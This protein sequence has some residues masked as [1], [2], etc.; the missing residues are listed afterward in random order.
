MVHLEHPDGSTVE[1]IPEDVVP[2]VGRMSLGPFSDPGL[3]VIRSD[4]KPVR[5]LVT[6]VNDGERAASLPSA[7]PEAVDDWLEPQDMG[8]TIAEISAGSAEL[9]R[10]LVL[11]ALGML[12][13]ET[14]LA[15]RTSGT[16]MPSE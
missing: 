11:A 13:V 1:L 10:L 2:P 6:T 15:A 5:L 9:T 12:V 14:F 4:D 7:R 3:Y 16:G 8:S